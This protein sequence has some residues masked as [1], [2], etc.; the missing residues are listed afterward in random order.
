MQLA[1][2]HHELLA[3]RRVERL[4]RQ[5]VL[6][7]DPGNRLG[8]LGRFEAAERVGDGD[9]V[10]NIDEVGLLRCR[11]GHGSCDNT[12]DGSCVLIQR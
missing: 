6:F 4:A 5:R 2:P 10:E 9:A 1:Q 7:G 3:Q 8:I 12:K 11:V